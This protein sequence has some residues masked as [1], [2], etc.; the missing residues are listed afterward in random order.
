M[1]LGFNAR[2]DELEETL[3]SNRPDYA[4]DR[5]KAVELEWSCLD[6]YLGPYGP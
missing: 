3:S 1:E 6:G 2:Q 4:S 5:R